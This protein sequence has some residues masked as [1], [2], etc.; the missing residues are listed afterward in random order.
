VR[1]AALD[2]GSNSFHLIVV[3][4]HADGSFET[5]LRE[6]DVLR[7]ADNVATTHRIPPDKVASAIA[8]VARLRALAE[9]LNAEEWVVCATSALRE[10][11][12]GAE[13]VEQIERETG[14]GIRVI[15][16]TDE[17]RLIFAAVR[18]SVLLDKPP[19]VCIDQGGGSLEVSVGDQSGLLWA[20]SV[21]LGAVR[22]TAQFIHSDPPAQS[23][24]GAIREHTRKTLA[25]IAAATKKFRPGMLVATSGSLTTLAR[26]AAPGLASATPNA[27]HQLIVSAE[28]L[29]AVHEKAQTLSLDERRGIDGLDSR[30]A[31]ILPAG[32]VVLQVAMELFGFDEL[33]VSEWSMREGMVLDAIGHHD[34]FDFA[35][36]RSMRGESVRSLVRR[37]GGNE[38]H[39]HQVFRLALGIFDDLQALHDLSPIDRE[40][41]GHAA[42]LH[43]IGEHIG[44]DNHDKHTAYL[45]EHGQLRGFPPEEVVMLASIGRFHRRGTPKPSTYPPMRQLTDPDRERVNKLTAIL[46]VADGLDRS[47]DDAV[48]DVT[49]RVHADRI[50]LTISGT[51]DLDLERW[52]VRRKRNL[53]EKAFGLPIDVRDDDQSSLVG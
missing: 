34:P 8:S 28:D 19:A 4:A 48:D 11:D 36:P 42:W 29:A 52:G 26:L 21:K 17:A 49:A 39:A 27:M 23:E 50:E 13:V 51:G 35:D 6:K 53:F 37:Y 12:N 41:L 30:R 5:L 25:P 9:A 15:T 31:E 10:A 45:I 24:L 47:H 1:I 7:L 14:V 44:M 20:R 38:R 46:R 33:T 2:L 16:G 18:A 22:L 40:L 32:S 3:D 43:D